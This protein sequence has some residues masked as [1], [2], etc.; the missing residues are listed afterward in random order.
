MQIEEVLIVINNNV[1]YGIDTSVIQQIL[2]V[3]NL[4]AI[5]YA[6]KYTK[7]L[8]SI[9]GSV[10]SAVDF[11]LL[12]ND[13][14]VDLKSD[15]SRAIVINNE[16][17][18][19]ALLVSEV[20]N[21]ITL[22]TTLMDQID[23]GDSANKGTYKHADGLIQILDIFELF[24]LIEA[25]KIDSKEVLNGVNRDKVSESKNIDLQRYLVFLM[26]E[27]QFALKVDYLQEIIAVPYMFTY[28]AGS[29]NYVEGM[30]SLRDELLVV[31]DVRCYY[32]YAVSKS[33]KNK[34][35]VAEI[36][37]KKL[38]LIVDE[39]IDIKDFENSSIDDM[40]ANFQDEKVSGVIHD[41]DQLISILGENILV[42][43]MKEN[44]RFAEDTQR[45]TELNEEKDIEFEVVIFK[46][47]DIEYA[48]DIDHVDE[49]IDMA[50]ITAVVD[51]PDIVE[52]LINIRGKIVTMASLFNSLGLETKMNTTQKILICEVGS[53]KIGFNVDQITDVMGVY[54]NDIKA[55]SEEDSYFSN[56]LHLDSG[57]RLVL[58]VDIEKVM[59]IEE[60]L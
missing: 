49:I 4:T 27:E 33:D 59:R 2:H 50:H 3:P 32:N 13:K 7:G 57:N 5:P 47:H 56:I 58:M 45:E 55:D 52:G 19:S 20:I 21:S 44:D 8:C 6:P 34:I 43:M 14:C 15:R 51:T 24:N 48:L 16:G 17:T 46:L 38:G 42:K 12:L 53:N 22:D 23:S 41:G 29:Q 26:G 40:P 18:L 35:L 36:N 9:S 31:N 10:I 39:I 11:N 37:K 1:K 28:I 30:I 60:T 25:E 54:R